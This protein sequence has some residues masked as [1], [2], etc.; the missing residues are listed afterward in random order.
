MS[1]KP[2][3]KKSRRT[4][5]FAA[6]LA[7]ALASIWRS[8]PPPADRASSA[9]PVAP[10]LMNGQGA[11]SSSIL[12]KS[13]PVNSAARYARIVANADGFTVPDMQPGLN[14]PGSHWKNPA[15]TVQPIFPIAFANPVRVRSGVADVSAV[16]L[17]ANPESRAELTANGNL[18]YAN[19]FGP[20]IDVIYRCEPLK[21]EEYIVI[22]N[23]EQS[24][25]ASPRAVASTGAGASSEAVASPLFPLP[26]R[27]GVGGGVVSLSA[28]TQTQDADSPPPVTRH[29]SPVTFSWDLNP[30]ALK[31]RLTPGNTIELCDDKAVPRLRIN[32][33]EGKDASG[34]PLRIGKE[35]RITLEGNRVTL[36]ADTEGLEFPIVID[37]T[38][39]STGAMSLVRMRAT[40]TLLNSGK[41][42][43]AGGIGESQQFIDTCEVF[44]PLSESWSSTGSFN[45]ARRGH[46]A[47]V[48][49]NG[50]VLV[51]GGENAYSSCEIFD[52]IAGQWTATNSLN[53][54]RSYHTCTRLSDGNVVVIG[55]DG[56]QPTCEIFDS[57]S[58][59]WTNAGTL[60]TGRGYHKA[61]GLSGDRVLVIGGGP[62]AGPTLSSCEIY[63]SIAKTSA[64]TG[65]MLHSRTSH[66]ATAL[67]NGK[68]F[69]TGG[70][71]GV[72]NIAQ[73]E[74]YDIATGSWTASVTM[75]RA[76]RH[77]SACLL[78]GGKLLISGGMDDSTQI[79]S[80]STVFDPV[81]ETLG[82]NR[83]FTN[84][85]ARHDSVRLL[86]SSVLEACGVS[87][88][89]SIFDPEI[90][91]ITVSASPII[92]SLNN[93]ITFSAVASDL[94]NNSMT[95][96]W[97]F[98][99]GE[100][101]NEQNPQHSYS[102]AGIFSARVT[103]TGPTGKSSSA[104]IAI[105]TSQP[106]I[107]RLQ[108]SDVVAFATQ[109]FTFD[110]STSSDPENAIASYDWDF[111]DGTPHGSQQIITKV[112]N[113]PG[114]Y[115]ITL[116]ITDSAG[117]SSSTTRVIEVLAASEV[118]LY[119]GFMNYKV[120]WNRNAE[121]KDTLSFDASVNVGDD[122]I[123]AG[124]PV[125]IEI[126]GQRFEG[127]LD[128][129]LRDFTNLN[130]K[131]TVKAGIRHQPS[132][133]VSVKLALKKADLG[134]AFNLAG[135]TVGGDPHDI[136]S[137]DI[138][139]HLEVG[140]HSFELQVPTDFKFTG[141]GTR[142]KGDGASE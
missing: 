38:W 43:A 80:E 41:V 46:T 96:H 111:G 4:V 131:W 104:T 12:A 85:A 79:F 95:Y 117:V 105:T 42:L 72:S 124:T 86:D 70:F 32:A 52:P 44:D 121:S 91:D 57:S 139:V 107:V 120:N 127:T 93:P 29:M 136:V 61:I 36:A 20:G 101:S 11:Q 56:A 92:Q 108:T 34:K 48:L 76:L 118:G 2:F 78:S 22:R 30:G 47:I 102:S 81:A 40:L 53:N 94:D 115:T 15:K 97:E 33:P 62:E 100:A 69:V 45:T 25:V 3:S 23:N 58:M 135:V 13:Y 54:G 27:E 119:N 1:F 74:E 99:D 112:Y 37:P 17:N 84:F 6:L 7:I 21:T 82:T 55:G 141:G 140:A 137:K 90:P 113:Q 50:N 39:S 68:V 66:T 87:A 130:E 98:G 60:N 89:C 116:T 128:R 49:N 16:P 133:T 10:L 110:A 71:D 132:G 103:A 134:S 129:K 63:D 5:A 142:A 123:A 35:L 109:A 64:F 126:V 26:L 24:E 67:Q 18:I 65:T 75:T 77:Q 14:T 31:P 73:C 19:A 9:P 88:G 114:T 83:S 59:N 125:A 28:S 138:T 106:P 122:V 51:V 8:S